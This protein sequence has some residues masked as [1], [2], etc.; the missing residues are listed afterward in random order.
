MSTPYWQKLRD[1]RWQRK[2]LEIMERDRFSCQSCG[3]ETSTLN[4]HHKYYLRGVSPWDYADAALITLCEP[5][6][7]LAEE[8]TNRLNVVL[9]QMD[10]ADVDLLI[11]WCLG[12]LLIRTAYGQKDFVPCAV[13][14]ESYEEGTGFALATETGTQWTADGKVPLAEYLSRVSGVAKASDP[15]LEPLLAAARYC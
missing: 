12:K 11:G 2:R 8:K 6:H 9:S 5:C 10:P 4:V 3:N 13:K 1:P 14:L 15:Q 7:E